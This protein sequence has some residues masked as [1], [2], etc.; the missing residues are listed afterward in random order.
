MSNFKAN[1]HQIWFRL[2]L[3]R[4]RWGAYSAPQTSLLDLMSPTSKGRGG[5]KKARPKGVGR[6]GRDCAVLEIP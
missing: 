4:P 2:G 5:E 6:K 3:S 1:M